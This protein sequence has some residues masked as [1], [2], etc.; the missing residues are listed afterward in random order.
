MYIFFHT[1]IHTY[2]HIYIYIYTYKVTCA[3]RGVKCISHIVCVCGSVVS[4]APGNAESRVRSARAQAAGTTRVPLI[5]TTGFLVGGAT[6]AGRS[7]LSP[8]VVSS[9]MSTLA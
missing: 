4:I 5:A 8:R 2:I 7:E 1:Y 9:F 6:S 3:Q